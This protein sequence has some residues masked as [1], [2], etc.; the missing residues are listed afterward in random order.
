[1]PQWRNILKEKPKYWLIAIVII[2]ALL[3][4][5][6]YYKYIPIGIDWIN[7][8]RPVTL[9]FLSGTTPYQGFGMFNPPWILIPFIPLALL[10]EKVGGTIFFFFAL[11]SYF[12][13]LRKLKVNLITSLIF[14]FSP[15]VLED[16]RQC[17][18]NWLVMLGY[19]MP[20]QIG[21]FFVL[22]KPQVGGIVALYWFIDAWRKGGLKLVIR[23][24]LPV[25]IAFAIS[26]LIYGFWFTGSKELIGNYW[27][28]SLF[29]FSIAIGLVLITHSLQQRDIHFAYMAA[30]FLSPY[31]A[32]YSYSTVLLGLVTSTWNTL[33]ATIGIWATF[34]VLKFRGR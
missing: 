34:V 28:T 15:P 18:I 13:I 9:A 27:N 22:M 25:T 32:I 19:I 2:L 7:S 12:I 8:Y 21:L 23:T 5:G 10:P 29:P 1:M 6:L 11:T 3:A 17:N 31:V 33:A 26:F 16:L 4:V 24:Y 30:P 20:P 14:F